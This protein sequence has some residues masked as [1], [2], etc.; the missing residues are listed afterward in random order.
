MHPYEVAKAS[1]DLAAQ[2]FGKIYDLRVAVT[3]CGNFFGPA[4]TLNFTRL[5]PSACRS[6]A[7]GERPVLRSD[8]LATR[9]FVYI[10]DAVEAQM[11]LARRLADDPTLN[12]EAFNFLYGAPIE[13]REISGASPPCPE[14]ISNPCSRTP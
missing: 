2:S 7:N 12:G 1:Q 8:G 3:R 11:L 6:L 9:D 10:E 5:M 14:R 13:V 4:M